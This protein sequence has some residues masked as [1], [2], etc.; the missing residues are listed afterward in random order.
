MFGV[1]QGVSFETPIICQF[2]NEIPTEL[3]SIIIP[4]K[5]VI[6]KSKLS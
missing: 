5:Y 2:P 3:L 6:S 4:V 1:Y